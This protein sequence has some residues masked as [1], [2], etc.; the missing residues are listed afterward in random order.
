MDGEVAS[1][2]DLTL[3]DSG[4]NEDA[5]SERDDD[6]A[7]YDRIIARVA[8][9]QGYYEAAVTEQRAGNYPVRPGLAVRLP[10]LAYLHAWLGEEV[11]QGLSVLLL[12]AAAWAWRARF[13]DEPGGRRYRNFAAALIVLGGAMVLNR[14]YMVLHEVW[15]GML[16]ALSLGLHRPGKWAASLLVAAL[17]IAL[18]ELALPYVLLMAVMAAWRRDWRE[19]GAWSLLIAVYAA[20]L[21]WHLGQ[22]AELVRPDDPM[23][24]S[25]LAMD[26][27]AGW[28]SKIVLS[29]NLRFLPHWLAGPLALL[30]ILGWAG[31]KSPAGRTAALLCM[32]YALA[33]MI[34]GRA[35][36]FYWGAII[37]PV[38]F[39][40]L[41]LVPMSLSSLIRKAGGR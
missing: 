6:L 21:I 20:V 26:G 35:H 22:I 29:S 14:Y 39:V 25:W 38:M 11:L 27:L 30:M 37:S 7:L 28:L 1:V 31:W 24:P 10:T 12:G 40:G 41:A 32:G 2:P 13:A 4:A 8:D 16:V 33:F 34:A 19:A 18:R 5:A 9:G 3:A 15:T 23:G 17:A 36:N